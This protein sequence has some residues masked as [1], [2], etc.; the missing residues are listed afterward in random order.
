[1]YSE[2]SGSERRVRHRDRRVVLSCWL[3]PVVERRDM[4]VGR[5]DFVELL[6]RLNIISGV[7][8]YFYGR[9]ESHYNIEGV[10]IHSDSLSR[11]GGQVIRGGVSR[12]SPPH[13]F[14]RFLKCY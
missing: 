4:G 8:H 14:L 12:F 2:S 6:L 13:S 5:V 7:E 3:N 11:V 10:A 1:M 9:I